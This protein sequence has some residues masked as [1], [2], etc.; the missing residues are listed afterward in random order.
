MLTIGLDSSA[1]APIQVTAQ[2]AGSGGAPL[3]PGVHVTGVTFQNGKP[4]HE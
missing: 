3:T 1:E 2:L 4:T